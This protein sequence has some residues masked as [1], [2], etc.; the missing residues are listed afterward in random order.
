MFSTCLYFLHGFI[1]HIVYV[2]FKCFFIEVNL[3][4]MCLLCI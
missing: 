4:E 3:N 2:T 1:Y